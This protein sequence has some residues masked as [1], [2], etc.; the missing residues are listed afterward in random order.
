MEFHIVLNQ[1]IILFIILIIGFVAGKFKIMDSNGTKKLSEVLLFVTSP[2]LVLNSFFIKFSQERIFNVLWIVGLGTAMFIVAIVL[3]KLIYGRF[4]EKIAPVLRFTAIFSN[5]GYMGLPLMKALYGDNGVFYGSFYIVLFHMFLWSYGFMMFGGKGT[6]AQVAKKVLTNPSIIAVYFGLIIF[7][8][9][10]P[11][12]DP[13]RG[14]VKAVGDMTMP[15][16]MLIIGG[17]MSTAKLSSVFKDWRVY[18]ASAVRLVLM[19]LIAI[20]ATKALGIQTLPAAVI[21]TALA[22][23]AAANTT[24][25]SEMFE[26]DAVFASKCV[27]VSTL[28]SIITAPLIISLI[29]IV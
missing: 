13:V 20:F 7:I 17:V 6:K 5:C 8:L 15:I 29:S 28:L 3:S 22:M 12:P 1:V 26:K 16:S 23:P 21:G 18:M 19:P 27:T 14:A 2:M 9:S 10:I 25:F 4:N 24:I 11:I